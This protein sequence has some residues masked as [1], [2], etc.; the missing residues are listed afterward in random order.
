[1]THT[2]LALTQPDWSRFM[3]PEGL[4]EKSGTSRVNFPRMILKELADN[5]ADAGGASLAI[6][7]ADTVRIA[8]TGPGI[9]AVDL[10]DVFSIKRPLVSTKHWRMGRRGALG[11]GLRAAMGGL[12]VL[13]GRLQ[14]SS[15][16]TT[17]TVHLNE[18][19][20]TVVE[21]VGP[22]DNDGTEIIVT[23][24]SIA[25]EHLSSAPDIC[26][27]ASAMFLWL[28][29]AVANIMQ[30]VPKTEA[31]RSCS[32]QRRCQKSPNCMMLQGA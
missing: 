24:R 27:N 14:V 32:A 15:R 19:G 30:F 9:A 12:Y 4:A 6:I 31:S 10:A 29:L 20:D 26:T 8:D 16:G 18:Q 1:M 28:P 21:R 7:D 3:T 22:S 17:S 5:A 2:E 13:G 25:S 11:N 23:C